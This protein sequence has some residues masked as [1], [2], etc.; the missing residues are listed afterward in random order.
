MASFDAANGVTKAALDSS[1][2]VP[3]IWSDEIVAT[4][5]KSLVMA[6][7]VKKLSVVGK[8][9]D[10]VHLPGFTRGAASAKGSLA[11]VTLQ[12]HSGTGV[13]VNLDQHWEYSRLIEDIAKVQSNNPMR[14]VYTE[15]AGYALGRA[16]DTYLI[17]LASAWKGGAGNATYDKA[18]IGSDGSTLYTSGANNAAAITDVAIRKVIQTLDD[19]DVPMDGR[20][21]VI[22]PVA[23]NTLMGL[24]RFTE[25]AFV[26]NGNVIQTGRL[27]NIY[28]IEAYVTS[29]CA[30]ATGGARIALLFHKDALILCEQQKPRVQT[31]YKQEF[32]A[33]LLTADEIFGAAELRDAAGV[34]IAVPA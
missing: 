2:F 16:I 25:Q 26:G 18:V 4:Y 7:L 10:V 12:A 23:R 27:G 34:A 1:K 3:E 9:G 11:Q 15:D 19:A 13:D 6:N 5:K 22:P 28:G 33:D 8:K 20:S 21:L 29:A 14:G 30:T 17:N 31:Q 24:A 32:L